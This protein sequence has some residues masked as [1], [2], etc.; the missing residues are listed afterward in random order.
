LRIGPKCSRF[1]MLGWGG[2]DAT[3]RRTKRRLEPFPGLLKEK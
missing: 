3:H 1:G 2:N